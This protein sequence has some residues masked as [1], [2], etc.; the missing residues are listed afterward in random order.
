MF[1]V[2]TIRRRLVSMFAVALLLMTGMAVSG[3]FGLI[4]HQE[5]VDDLDFL[6]HR[7]PNQEHLSRAVSRVSESFCTPLDLRKPEAVNELRFSYVGHL[8]DA[9]SAL[10]DFRRRI[11]SL[12]LT[13]QLTQ[14]Q[15]NQVLFRLD[16]IYGELYLLSELVKDFRPIDSGNDTRSF[17][18][19][20][21]QAD[22]IVNRIQKGLETLPA[23]QAKNWVALSLE[24]ER[25]RSSK[26]LQ[27]LSWGIVAVGVIFLLLLTCGFQWISTPVR[28]IAHGCTRIANGDIAYRLQ[29]VSRWQDEFADLVAGVNCV[30]DRFQQAEEDLLYKVKERSEQ[31]I[32]SQKLANVGFLAAGVAHE[33]NNPLSA[34]SMAAESLEFRL[35]ELIGLQTQEAR[36]AMDRV[37]MIRRESRRC[38]DITAR[39]LDFS[40]GEKAGRLPA[41]IA[42][43]VREVL[44]IVHHLGQYQ[45]RRVEFDCDRCVIAE[46]NSAQMKQVI[47]NLVANALQATQAGGVVRIRLQEQVDNLVLAISDDGCGMDTETLQ[48]IFDPFFTTRETG[49]GTGLGLSITHR[50]VEDHGGTVTPMSEGANCGSTFQI[51]LPRRQSQV[52]AA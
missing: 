36:E 41:D 49:Q 39:L 51:R 33:I 13:T 28:A 16:K 15:R 8:K 52:H 32:R 43:L 47:L 12:P 17:D 6:L 37:A 3:I 31:L 40:R 50:I 5:A 30:A 22:R 2:R 24:K 26:L 48:H 35:Y 27:F 11:E 10:F 7:S 4:W 45:D 20:Q 38:G 14:Q 42:E 1:L 29:T 25:E 23:Y 34:I 46:V 21:L 19:L 44:A 18:L 9:E